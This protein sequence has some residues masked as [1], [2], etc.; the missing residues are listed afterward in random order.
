MDSQGDINNEQPAAMR[1]RVAFLHW[2]VCLG[3]FILLLI[4][5]MS[6]SSSLLGWLAFFF[7]IG[8]GIYLNRG[9][10]RKLIEWHPMYNT[11][12]NV[13]STKLKFFLFWP[14]TYFFLFMRLGVNKVL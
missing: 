2:A 8:A 10:L 7:Y 9:V 12:Y 6:F 5:A 1:L 11:L 14:L 3:G 13:T 4:L